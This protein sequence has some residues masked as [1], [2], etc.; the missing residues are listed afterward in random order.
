MNHN[1]FQS[2]IKTI[3]NDAIHNLPSSCLNLT[4]SN[5]LSQK[6][7]SKCNFSEKQKT[8]ND[9]YIN[10][11]EQYSNEMESFARYH[12]YWHNY[13][14]YYTTCQLL[15]VICRKLIELNYPY[16]CHMEKGYIEIVFRQEVNSENI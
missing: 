4:F 16:I 10:I 15:S 5:H 12:L 11:V 8:L 13:Y 6:F 9:F 3:V 1:K 2:N 7:F 14:D